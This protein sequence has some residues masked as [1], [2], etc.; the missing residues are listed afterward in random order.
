MNAEIIT[1]CDGWKVVQ[2]WDIRNDFFEGRK[3]KHLLM[4]RERKFRRFSVR[5]KEG[6]ETY[7]EIV[8]MYHI[9]LTENHSVID[10]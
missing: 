10:K 9:S 5:Y 4:L 6:L 1:V 7:E 8:G 2:G 3:M